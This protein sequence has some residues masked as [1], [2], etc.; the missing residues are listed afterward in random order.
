[1]NI[2]PEQFVRKQ[3]DLLQ[4]IVPEGFKN[5]REYIHSPSIS[6]TLQS[7]NALGPAVNKASAVP[8]LANSRNRLKKTIEFNNLR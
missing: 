4:N 8:V 6:K 2:F 1:L 7:S 3:T 5:L